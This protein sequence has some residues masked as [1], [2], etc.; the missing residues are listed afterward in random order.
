MKAELGRRVPFKSLFELFFGQHVSMEVLSNT[1]ISHLQI[2]LLSSGAWH[3]RRS[4]QYD[5]S[6]EGGEGMVCLTS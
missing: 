4:V 3:D 6:L 2:R 5:A 1:Y